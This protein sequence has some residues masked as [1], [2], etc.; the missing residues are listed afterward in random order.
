MGPGRTLN[1]VRVQLQRMLLKLK[2]EL[3]RVQMQ[4]ERPQIDSVKYH[5]LDRLIG[6]YRGRLE[7]Y[8][9]RVDEVNLGTRGMETI[10]RNVRRGTDEWWRARHSVESHDRNRQALEPLIAEVTAIIGEIYQVGRTPTFGNMAKG[11][12]KL[13]KQ[14]EQIMDAASH[15]GEHQILVEAREAHHQHL[16]Q[17]HAPG[18]L[19][20]GLSLW[21]T[22]LTLMV[23]LVQNRREKR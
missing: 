11:I 9:R 1:V 2:G 16:V 17:P 15:G 21:L 20:S 18:G 23:K 3:L 8:K 12:D 14:L 19:D 7:Q 6:K 4:P 10:N 5:D 22:V 13:G